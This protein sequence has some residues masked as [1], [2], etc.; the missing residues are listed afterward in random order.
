MRTLLLVLTLLPVASQQTNQDTD[1]LLNGIVAVF[2]EADVITEDTHA[3]LDSAVSAGKLS[4]VD[5]LFLEMEALS[6]RTL[7]DSVKAFFAPDTYFALPPRGM[8]P[9]KHRVP[10]GYRTV[11]DYLYARGILNDSCIRLLDEY[12]F[13]PSFALDQ[14][15]KSG[16]LNHGFIQFFTE[17]EKCNAPR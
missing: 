14:A 3:A 11:V 2:Y 15:I 5:S 16:T 4:T 10:E 12:L 9:G 17:L 1:P 6:F 7:P 8:F 13:E